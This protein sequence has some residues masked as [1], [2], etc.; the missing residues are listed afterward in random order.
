MEDNLIHE[1]NVQRHWHKALIA[2]IRSFTRHSF[3]FLLSSLE[4]TNEAKADIA[5]F[6]SAHRIMSEEH[7]AAKIDTYHAEAIQKQ[8]KIEMI[9]SLALI[10]IV[11]A[12][13]ICQLPFLPQGKEFEEYK[14][15]YP[16]YSLSR[17]LWILCLLIPLILL[18]GARPLARLRARRRY[19]RTA[20]ALEVY[21]DIE[22]AGIMANAGPIALA[23]AAALML[24]LGFGAHQLG[25]PIPL[26]RQISYYLSN[27][28]F[29]LPEESLDKLLLKDGKLTGEARDALD[30]VLDDFTPGSEDALKLATYIVLKD[31]AG[32]PADIARENLTAQIA[33][34]DDGYYSGSLI[35]K[36]MDKVP[37]TVY[38]FFDHWKDSDDFDTPYELAHVAQRLR[39]EPL[40]ERIEMAQRITSRRMKAAA[41]L[42]ESVTDEDLPA[43]TNLLM[44]TDNDEQLALYAGAITACSI[45]PE[46]ITPV[47]YRLRETGKSLAQLFPEGI[48]LNLKVKRLNTAQGTKERKEQQ[49]AEGRYLAI[50]CT[51]VDEPAENKKQMSPADYDGHNKMSPETFQ[52]TVNTTVMDLLPMNRV[53]AD[54]TDCDWL[55]ITDMSYVYG[56]CAGDNVKSNVQETGKTYYYPVYGREY[57]LLVAERENPDSQQLI[58]SLSLPAPTDQVVRKWTN[59]ATGA[60][61]ASF[62]VACDPDDSWAVTRIRQY[63][64]LES[65][66]FIQKEMPPVKGD[67]SFW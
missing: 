10:L 62:K 16:H 33:A 45:R 8:K 19:G 43:L 5:S 11:F 24:A 17:M 53:P 6:L 38:L 31:N 49:P 56:G 7:A 40:A 18:I 13:L 37:W 41:F 48:P 21:C 46:D 1:Q 26:S 67:N 32:Y 47:L 30:E 2:W 52:I 42:K 15:T 20:K 22:E 4:L 28:R 27:R 59:V 14:N 23:V 61:I 64:N 63:F 39:G 55:L 60:A 58:A 34:I 36:I 66:R 3:L 9:W 35:E 44:S 54:Y 25:C 29:E 51:E 50:D 12:V 57:R 65:S